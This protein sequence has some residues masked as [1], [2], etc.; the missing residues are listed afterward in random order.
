MFFFKFFNF[1]I[2]VPSKTVQVGGDTYGKYESHAT[3][4]P[5]FATF[6]PKFAIITSEKVYFAYCPLKRAAAWATL[7]FD[8]SPEGIPKQDVWRACQDAPCHSIKVG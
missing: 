1:D 4:D 8:S 3:I 7:N 5:H 6:N 2:H